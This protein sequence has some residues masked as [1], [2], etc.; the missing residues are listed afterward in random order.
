MPARQ[1][2]HGFSLTVDG[3]AHGASLVSFT[4]P[5]RARDA[6]E[7]SHQGTV[8]DM[9]Y[10]PA[11]LRDPGEWSFEFEFD[12]SVDYFDDNAV[13]TW[14]LTFPLSTGES[15]PAYYQFSGFVTSHGGQD[16]S[17]GAL[18]RPSTTVKQTGSLTYVEAV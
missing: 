16:G 4:M 8:D 5:D 1:E 6:L 9:T 15:T 14:R 10:A 12:R 3:T 2:G 7:T 11:A 13:H 18:M 17:I